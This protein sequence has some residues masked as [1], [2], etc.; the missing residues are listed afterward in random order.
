LELSS[1]EGAL[2][3]N[4]NKFE[5]GRDFRRAPRVYGNAGREWHALAARPADAGPAL[6][7]LTARGI[8]VADFDGDGDLDVVI[9]QNNGSPLLLRNDQHSGLPWLRLHLVATR[10]QPDAGGAR[11]EVQTPR[12][13]HVQTVAPAL[14]FMAQSESTLTFGLGDDARVRR[15]VIHWPSGQVQELKPDGLSRTLEIRE[16]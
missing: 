12:R 2:E 8:A 3:P 14:G 10:S 4:L 11:V 15:I 7:A 5:D 13:V 16:P 1:G 9:A 6:P